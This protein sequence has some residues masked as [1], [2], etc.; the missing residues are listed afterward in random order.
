M[1]PPHA[2]GW[3]GENEGVH[4]GVPASPARAGMDPVEYTRRGWMLSFP[5]TRGDGPDHRFRYS[6][7]QPLPPHARGWTHIPIRAD[8]HQGASPA[9]AGMDPK[10]GCK[11]GDH[12]SFPRTRGD[13]PGGL[14]GYWQSARLPPHA[15]GWTRESARRVRPDG[16]SPARAGMDLRPVAR[17]RT[18]GSFPRTRGDGPSLERL[19]RP[20]DS[21]PPHAR[22]WTSLWVDLCVSESVS[23]ARAGMDRRSDRAIEG[24]FGFPRTRGDGPSNVCASTSAGVLPPH[25][26]GWTLSWM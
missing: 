2:R 12:V 3:T 18:H 14:R 15:R 6:Y 24:C 22:G 26:R 1:L 21:F 8:D 4:E 17:R 11:Q 7:K 9:R 10:D 25:A 16:V 23:P 20:L 5:R 19:N 13:G